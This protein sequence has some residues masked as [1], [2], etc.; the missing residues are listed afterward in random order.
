MRHPEN[1]CGGG[2]AELG[3]VMLAYTVISLFR[4]DSIF[5]LLWLDA[6]FVL[7][8]IYVCVFVYRYS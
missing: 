3:L 1:V 8:F 4:K 5:K 6:F 7:G 2:E